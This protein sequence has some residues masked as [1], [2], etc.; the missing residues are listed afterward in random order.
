MGM[1]DMSTKAVRLFAIGLRD[2][3]ELL[4]EGDA[5]PLTAG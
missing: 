5:A 2:P 3:V 4:R 1:R